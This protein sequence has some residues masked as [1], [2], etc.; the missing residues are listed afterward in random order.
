LLA[1]AGFSFETITLDIDESYP[2]EILPKDVAKYLAEKKNLAYREKLNDEIVITAD[3]TVIFGNEILEKPEDPT[4]ARM[5]LESLSG[6]IHSVI[7]GVCISS[8]KKVVTFDDETIVQFRNLSQQEITHYIEKFKPFDKAGAYG[9]QEWIGLVGIERIE[10]SY[11]NVMGLPTLKVY[12]V[13]TK[14]FKL[15]LEQ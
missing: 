7:T 9:I 12:K 2:K 15:E 8:S 1:E 4:D 13:L 5:M 10:G 6:Q 3:T 14:D 11:F